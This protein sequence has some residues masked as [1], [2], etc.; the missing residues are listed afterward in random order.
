MGSELAIPASRP[1]ESVDDRSR[2]VKNRDQSRAPLKHKQPSRSI[3]RQALHVAEV[4]CVR[5]LRS[6][7]QI[8]L[9]DLVWLARF[10]TCREEVLVIHRCTA[11]CRRACRLKADLRLSPDI[12]TVQI[13]G[14]AGEGCHHQCEGREESSLHC[15]ILR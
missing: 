5:R 13:H 1:A 10:H 7:I 12:L 14:P 3:A 8:K 11:K 2:R 15:G 4:R 6:A 9:Q